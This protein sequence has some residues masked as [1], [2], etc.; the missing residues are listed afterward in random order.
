MASV[1]SVASVTSMAS[2]T[3]KSSKAFCMNINN[4]MHLINLNH[5][6]RLVLDEKTLN[7]Y[8]NVNKGIVGGIFGVVGFVGG[9]ELYTL[10][11]QYDTKELAQKDFDDIAKLM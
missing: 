10:N 7:I 3:S 5:V 9:N 11:V 4:K 6:T 2:M 1:A 8:F